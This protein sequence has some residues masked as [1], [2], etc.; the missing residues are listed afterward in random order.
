[1]L[2]IE[3]QHAM[4]F[5]WPG[6]IER[7]DRRLVT[8]SKFARG[9]LTTETA[10]F[11]FAVKRPHNGYD[12]ITHCSVEL[13]LSRGTKNPGKQMSPFSDA[14]NP[15]FPPC[16]GCLAPHR[17]VRGSYPDNLLDTNGLPAT[18]GPLSP[19]SGGQGT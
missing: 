17:V 13:L 10:P 19:G 8:N 3:T 4:V 7:I 6:E 14:R 5:G 9:S 1:M 12:Q 18:R 15:V 16:P 2:D 11:C